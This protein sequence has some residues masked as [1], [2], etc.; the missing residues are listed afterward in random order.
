MT[1]TVSSAPVGVADTLPPFLLSVDLDGGRVS[2]HGELDQRHVHRLRE[3]VA[4]LAYSPAARW[5]LDVA[6]VTFCD[7]A[8]LR[9]LLAAHRLAADTG[10]SLVLTR[11]G[12][13]LRRLLHLA[14]LDELLDPADRL[15]AEP[16]PPAA[17]GTDG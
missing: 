12:P 17:R 10:R 14:G 11:S 5:S 7:A 4:V 1:V 16:G 15:P 8:G 2:L 3:A 6:G 13:W 9:V